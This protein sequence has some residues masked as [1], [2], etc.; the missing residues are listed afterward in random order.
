MTLRQ[1]LVSQATPAGRDLPTSDLS[2]RPGRSSPGPTLGPQPVCACWGQTHGSSPHAARGSQGAASLSP[3]GPSSSDLLCS[4]R[5]P[6]AQFFTQKPHNNPEKRPC[7][8][9]I[10]L[11]RKLRLRDVK[12]LLEV[13]GGAE[14]GLQPRPPSNSMA[15][16]CHSVF[17]LW[18]L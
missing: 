1:P 12:D 3:A 6:W 8:C 10:S 2:P 17:C 14:M 18:D 9:P 13:T 5:L 15:C 11:M 7:D 16:R 4:G